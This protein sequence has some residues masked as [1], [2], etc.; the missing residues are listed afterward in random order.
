VWAEGGFKMERL[1]KDGND[2]VTLLEYLAYFRAYPVLIVMAAI[3]NWQYYMWLST[4]LGNVMVLVLLTIIVSYLF[5]REWATNDFHMSP[6]MIHAANEIVY[7]IVTIL[8]IVSVFSASNPIFPLSVLFFTLICRSSA[9]LMQKLMLS[10]PES[11]LFLSP[12]IL[13]A[14]SYN[15]KT[16]DVIDESS[17][18]VDYMAVMLYGF[19]WGC[20]LSI[21]ENP[22][23]SGITV[24]CFFLLFCSALIAASVS[25]VPLT[26]GQVCDLMS[27][28]SVQD[29]ARVAIGKFTDRKLPLKLDM[30]GFEGPVDEVVQEKHRTHLET[31]REKNVLEIALEEIS[32]SRSLLL[33]K[34]DV[35]ED[36]SEDAIQPIPSSAD[37]TAEGQEHL[38][39]EKPP[40][41]LAQ[42]WMYFKERVRSIW[43]SLAFSQPTK[44][45]K[46]HSESLL[47]VIDAL[48]EAMMRGRG[49]MGFIGLD[50][51][52]YK[53]L[54]KVQLYVHS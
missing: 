51:L 24:T 31:L 43:A 7:A 2:K 38:E 8:A 4:L 6:R 26:L 34:Y 54:I 9:G 16:N 10:N 42:A 5:I 52:L 50:G 21:F 14:Y 20:A 47:T 11:I 25:Y 44:G 15:S 18:V 40:S 29:G 28:D 3:L 23:C 35:S 22:V 49:P 48:A 39:E 1:D 36:V 32:E 46:R 30:E 13:P 37:L 33:A 41:Q 45:Y 17:L 53:W 27:T 12:Y 19:L